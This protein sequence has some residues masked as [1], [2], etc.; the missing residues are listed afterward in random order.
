MFAKVKDALEEVIN[1]SNSCPD[2]YQLKCFEV[3]LSA[4]TRSET[5]PVANPATAPPTPPGS[6]QHA[7]RSAFFTQHGIDNAE[8]TRVFHLDGTSYNIIVG[9]LRTKPKSQKQVRLALLLGVKSLLE[10]GEPNVPKDSLVEMCKNYSAYDS[11]N[12]SGIMKKNRQF[13][14]AKGKDWVLTVPGQQR[15]AD[16]I[17]E[18]AQ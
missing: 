5:P 4:L 14:L 17:K 12:F 16:V 10:T 11:P 18:L 9:D 15:A 7:Q 3:L 6:I 8:W 2:K 13:F 1:L